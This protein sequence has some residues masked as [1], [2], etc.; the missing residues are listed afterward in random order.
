MS[1]FLHWLAIG[2]QAVNALSPIVPQKA[3][4]YI[5][6]GLGIGQY[7][8]HLLDPTASM[9]PTSSGAKP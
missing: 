7:V 4:G 6:I 5:A 3:Q 1:H 2:L 8:L 9:T